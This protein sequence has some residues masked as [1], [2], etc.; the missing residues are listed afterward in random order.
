VA[1]SASREQNDQRRRGPHQ[2]MVTE[3][4]TSR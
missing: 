1:R 3:A 4:R 2:V